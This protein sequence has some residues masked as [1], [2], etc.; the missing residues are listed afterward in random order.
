MAQGTPIESDKKSVNGNIQVVDS[1]KQATVTEVQADEKDL[2]QWQ[3]VEKEVG[4][5]ENAIEARIAAALA[6]PTEANLKALQ[7]A[8]G[9]LNKIDEEIDKLDTTT[10]EQ[11]MEALSKPIAFTQTGSD[12]YSIEESLALDEEFEE[13]ELS[14]ADP[15]S[16]GPAA[17][18]AGA[19]DESDQKSASRIGGRV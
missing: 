17:G 5:F 18:A 13:V 7:D 2:E 6:D 10:L 14:T 16:S 11:R 1:G 9:A 8:A 4:E 19:K 15:A 3:A 12:E